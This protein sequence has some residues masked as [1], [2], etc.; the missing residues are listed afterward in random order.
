[1]DCTIKVSSG[2]VPPS[3]LAADPPLLCLCL[4]VCSELVSGSVPLCLI[5]TQLQKQGPPPLFPSGT[6]KFPLPSLSWRLMSLSLKNPNQTTTRHFQL[7]SR[8][9][10]AP[11][12]LANQTREFWGISILC[13]NRTQGRIFPQAIKRPGKRWKWHLHAKNT[14][15]RGR[16]QNV[17]GHVTPKL[18]WLP[19]AKRS[20]HFIFIYLFCILVVIN[21]FSILIK[22]LSFPAVAVFIHSL[23]STLAFGSPIPFMF[24]FPMQHTFL[25]RLAKQ[26]LTCINI[27]GFEILSAQG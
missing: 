18:E 14:E 16:M 13:R 8:E 12:S 21:P 5:H 7:W 10:L 23:F 26:R 9:P 25:T 20:V 11:L 1:M 3:L 17:G 2:E 4:P 6:K 24:C 27:G 19:C 15:V 22:L